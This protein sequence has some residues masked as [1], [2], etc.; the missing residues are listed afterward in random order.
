MQPAHKFRFLVFGGANFE[1]RCAKGSL[2]GR[3]YFK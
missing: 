3:T 1:F 2:V